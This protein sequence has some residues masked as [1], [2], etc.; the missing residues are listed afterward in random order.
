[1]EIAWRDI[2]VG[3]TV[4]YLSGCNLEEI[5]IIQLA[6]IIW[7]LCGR[8]C[9]QCLHTDCP[10]SV[11]INIII[12]ILLI[13]LSHYP[14]FSKKREPGTKQFSNFPKDTWTLSGVRIWTQVFWPQD[15]DLNTPV[16]YFLC[17]VC[18]CTRQEMPISGSR[19]KADAG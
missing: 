4:K 13:I 17:L 8:H 16:Y 10:I 11:Q 5:F 18:L 7:L 15:T 9:A 2:L 1:M 14:C 6:F 19:N 12:Q 3:A